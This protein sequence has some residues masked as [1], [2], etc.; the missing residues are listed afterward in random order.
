[1]PDVLAAHGPTIHVLHRLRV[2]G[3]AMV[4]ADIVDPFKD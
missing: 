3:V 2:L 4:G 1:L